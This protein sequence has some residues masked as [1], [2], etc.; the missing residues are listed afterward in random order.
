[1]RRNFAWAFAALCLSCEAVLG[2]APLP[3]DDASNDAMADGASDVV[4][5]VDAGD[6]G[7]KEAG[8]DA[9]GT[10]GDSGYTCVNGGCGNEIVDL[11][12]GL[13]HACAVNRAGEVWCWGENSAQ[14]CGGPGGGA[15]SP[16][17]CR[18]PA[19]VAGVS[20]VVS[21]AAAYGSTCVADATGAVYCWGQNNN[22]ELGNDG[23]AT[24][25]PIQVSLPDKVTQVAGGYGMICAV[26][27]K[28]DL[29]CWG[30]NACGS[31]GLGF[32]GASDGGFYGY[33]APRLVFSGATSVRTSYQD[34]WG[35][36]CVTQTDG[37]VSCWGFNVYDS[38]TH[39][40]STILCG[41]ASG[42]ESNPTP[43]PY[44]LK[45]VTR[46]S[47]G[48]TT[49]AV[50]GGVVY[51]CGQNDYSGQLGTGDTSGTGTTTP[52]I[53]TSLPSNKTFVDVSAS[54]AHACALAQT[55]E[56]YCWGAPA[57]GE[58][59]TGYD[60]AGMPPQELCSGVPCWPSATR[61]GTIHATIVRT[62]GENGYAVDD[63]GVWAWGWNGFAQLGH[64]AGTG[65][66]HF[67]EQN[68]PYNAIP[69]RVPLP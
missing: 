11:S 30:L 18:L 17:T 38:L 3:G 58:L 45:G 50:A 2:I 33:F 60:D 32:E 9:C 37:G 14:Q 42:S 21:V 13:Y 61:V 26:T 36:T 5:A 16:N 35:S 67:D 24:S 1:M 10:C 62:G 4:V 7:A 39:Y 48:L 63:G 15:C 68:V 43:E 47:P 40:P 65:G 12:T 8:D 22:Q 49:C 44:P 27:I 20:N 6:G 19:K 64:A 31:M 66:D 41:G 23:G 28:N 55:G 56:V 29:Y 46:I 34:E 59:A 57:R 52:T 25:S 51:C 69:T 53:A 54:G